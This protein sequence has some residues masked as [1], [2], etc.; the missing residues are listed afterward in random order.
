MPR[1]RLR[2]AAPEH[3]EHPHRHPRAARAARLAAVVVVALLG[4]WLGLVLAGSVSL[5][6]GPVHARLS[7]APSLSGGTV[8]RIPPLGAIA[9]D[10]NDGPLEV[11]VDV[12]SIDPVAARRI[13]DDPGLLSGLPRQVSRDTRQAVGRVLAVGTVAAMGGAFVLGLVVFRRLRTALLSTTIVAGLVAGTLTSAALTLQ[14]GALREP[15]YSGL[16][17]SAPSLIGNAEDIAGDFTAYGDQLA[18]LVGNVSRLYAATSDLPLLP[19]A[20]TDTRVLLVSDI[21]LNPA[22]WPVIRSTV[23][24]Y[25]IDLVVDAGDLTDHGSRLEDGFAAPISTLGVPYVFVK[26]NHDSA[27][28][29]RAVRREEGAV[30]LDGAGVQV[31]DGIRF[32]GSPDPRFTPDKETAGT[33]AQGTALVQAQGQALAATARASDPHPDVVVVHDPTAGA[34]LA[35]AVPLVLSGHTH[36]RDVRQLDGGT[37]LFT[38]GSTGGAG[39]RG[40]DHDSPTPVELSVLYLDKRTHALTAWDDVT[41][42][43]L[44]LASA[45]VERHVVRPASTPPAGSGAAGGPGARSRRLAPTS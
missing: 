35:G 33:D 28:T 15:R 41:L 45:N 25:G 17:A 31:V 26:G 29:V 21:H 39:L 27:A 22:A 42:G 34:E 43:G 7:A 4:G 16:L 5:P 11:R 38:E 44:G 36:K 13:L 40:L 10:T 30:V 6:V 19:A 37:T 8:V 9:L 12:T 1:A 3:P 20:D 18:R 24:Q 2:A 14:K 32:L 23:A